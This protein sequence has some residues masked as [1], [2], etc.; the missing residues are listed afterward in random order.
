ME[1][2][3]Q[4]VSRKSSAVLTRLHGL[5]AFGAASFKARQATAAPSA[6]LRPFVRLLLTAYRPLLTPYRPSSSATIWLSAVAMPW[7][8]ELQPE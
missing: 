5:R 3:R 7:P 2:Y 8:T 1:G 6:Y 4:E